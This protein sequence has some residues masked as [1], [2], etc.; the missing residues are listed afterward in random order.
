MFKEIFDELAS[1]A[2][3]AK[4]L[5]IISSKVHRTECSMQERDCSIFASAGPAVA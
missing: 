2:Y 4:T 5:I 1:E 3:G